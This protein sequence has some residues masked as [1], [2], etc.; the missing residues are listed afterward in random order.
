MKTKITFE[1]YPEKSEGTVTTV[2]KDGKT[3]STCIKEVNF[4]RF[5]FLAKSYID[6]ESENIAKH[7]T[8]N[9]FDTPIQ[10]REYRA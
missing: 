4:Q 7:F 2:E 9:P 10:I 5:I 1:F 8:N 6:N 3:N